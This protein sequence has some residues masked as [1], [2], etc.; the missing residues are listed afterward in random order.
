M[1]S[2]NGTKLREQLYVHAILT[3]HQKNASN[4][5][6]LRSMFCSG[7]GPLGAELLQMFVRDGHIHLLLAYPLTV[8][9]LQIV[10]EY[11]H[12][13]GV[14]KHSLECIERLMNATLQDCLVRMGGWVSMNANGRVCSMKQ[15]G[16][17]S[18][19]GQLEINQ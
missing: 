11:M 16:N 1:K 12:G 13:T 4:A 3:S 8:S 19:E 7:H 6:R 10:S 5:K 14:L 9:T 17:T 18:Q 15:K 2:V